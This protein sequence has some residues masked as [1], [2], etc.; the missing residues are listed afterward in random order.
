M[1]NTQIE[2]MKIILL[3]HSKSVEGVVNSGKF[4]FQISREFLG[5]GRGK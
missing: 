4:P 1:Y 2:R 3:V 5:K